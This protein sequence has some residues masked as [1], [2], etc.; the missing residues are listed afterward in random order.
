MRRH[1]IFAVVLGLLGMAGA[2]YA[3]DAPKS[4]DAKPPEPAA[5]REPGRPIKVGIVHIERVFEKSKRWQDC[6]QKLR[7]MRQEGERNLKERQRKADLLKGQ[8]DALDVG[9]EDYRKTTE[10]LKR[11]VAEMKTEREVR[12][13]ALNRQY[14]QYLADFFF[15]LCTIVT[16]YG[17]ANGFDMILRGQSQPKELE[18]RETLRV[19]MEWNDVLYWNDALD[20]TDAIVEKMNVGYEGPIEEK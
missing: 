2:L 12:M 16:E 8:L 13:E 1:A 9:S 19:Q 15:S 7:I 14:D 10:E 17:K 20:I 6:D 4:D 18:K 5:K 3:Q 11:A